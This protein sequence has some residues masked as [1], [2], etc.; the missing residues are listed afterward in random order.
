MDRRLA[1][2]EAS[3]DAV[4]VLRVIPPH[5]AADPEQAAAFMARERAGIAG[6][7]RLV[8][9]NTGISRASDFEVA[10]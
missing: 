7:G 10:A 8:F 3:T 4:V 2:L 6:R 9:I 5:I 1:A